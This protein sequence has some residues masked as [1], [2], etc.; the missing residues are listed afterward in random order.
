[1]STLPQVFLARHGETAW[2]ITG[3]HTGRTDLP[4]TERG[5]RNARRL[6]ERL[7]GQRFG[8]VLVSPLLRARQTCELA[9]FLDGAEIDSDLVEWDY[10]DYEG[11]TTA[12]IRR[13][14]PNW[15]LF[16]DGCR[17]GESVAAI[18]A[19]ADRV[20]SRLREIREDVLVFSSG[21]FSRVLAARWLGVEASA[22]RY[23][24]LGTAT[25]SCLGY[26][27]TTAEPVLRLWNDA[28]HVGD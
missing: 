7:A 23:L 25:L 22:G 9:G 2:T 17:G 15:Q 6:G 12:E 18:S 24:Y 27:H 8:L 13:E 19:R 26:E 14:Q 16:L 21:H 20:I 28:R 11:R 4:L 1:M 5:Q 3:Q 10:G